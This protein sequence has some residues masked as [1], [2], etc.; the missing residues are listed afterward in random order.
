MVGL[1]LPFNESL[2]TNLILMDCHPPPHDFNDFS[3][4]ILIAAFKVLE[5]LSCGDVLGLL[6]FDAPT[7]GFIKSPT[8]FLL[9]FSASNIG[10]KKTSSSS[11]YLQVTGTPQSILLQTSFSGWHPYFIY[12]FEPGTKYIGGNNFFADVNENIVFTDNEEAQDIISDDEF[13][14]NGLK[15]ALITH[16]ITSAHI[17]GNGSKV[18]NFVIHPSVKT[19]QH[20]IFAEKIGEY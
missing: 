8:N 1:F 10:I 15:T 18:C 9:A 20:S 16:L 14:E 3:L 2:P 17:I 19:D 12:Y 7:N 11:I 13:P 4:M 5:S 6:M